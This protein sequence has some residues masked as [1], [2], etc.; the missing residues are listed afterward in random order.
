MPCPEVLQIADSVSEV[1]K[2]EWEGGCADATLHVE[3]A[4]GN[5]HLS[6]STG[7]DGCSGSQH[8]H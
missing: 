4:S 3:Q 1:Q 7:S 5:P 8:H 6:G 2:M